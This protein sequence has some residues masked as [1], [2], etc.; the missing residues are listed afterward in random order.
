MHVTALMF[1]KHFK[2][3]FPVR[4]AIM[5]KGCLCR[6][7]VQQTLIISCS[8]GCTIIL[9]CT[10]WSNF[11]PT[12]LNHSPMRLLLTSPFTAIRLPPFWIIYF[13][14][15]IRIVNIRTTW[16]LT[17]TI[18]SSWRVVRVVHFV[19]LT[20]TLRLGL[21][22]SSGPEGKSSSTGPVEDLLSYEKTAELFSDSQSET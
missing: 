21:C 15:V 11:I 2:S 8:T 16:A 13:Q 22:L 4:E 14:R 20:F 12:T 18:G 3:F 1:T 5:N 19:S 10:H 9:T 17:W 6:F 7:W